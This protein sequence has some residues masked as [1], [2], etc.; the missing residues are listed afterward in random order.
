[1]YNGF[2]Y[3]TN[4]QAKSGYAERGLPGGR[5][6]KDPFQPNTIRMGSHETVVSKR[7]YPALLATELLSLQLREDSLK[8]MQKLGQRST[9]CVQYSG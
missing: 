4:D 2:E 7:D 6:H 3:P 8:A 5:C 9:K 1:M